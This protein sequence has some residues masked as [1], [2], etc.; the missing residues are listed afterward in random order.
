MKKII[1]KPFFI[2]LF[3][4]EYWPF[5]VVYGPLF[6][7]WFFLCLRARSFF[8]FNTSNPTIKNGGFLMESKK[9]IYDLIPSEYYPATLF[10]KASTLP[11]DVLKQV[12]QINLKFP[13]VGKPDIGMKG[14]MV[15][16]LENENELFLYAKDSKVD[17]LVQEFVPYS[18]EAGI[19]YYRYPNEEIG[20]ISGVVKKE[21]LA[22]AGDGVSTLEQLLLQNKRAVLQLPVLRKTERDKMGIVLRN[23]EELIVVPY[24]NH[25]R[26][27]KF[28]DDS[29]L[30]DE[31]LTVTIDSICKKVNGFYFGRLDIRYNDWE[32]LKQGKNFSII[33]LN[34][35]GSEPT[36]IY[37]SKHS[38]FWAWK[39]IIKH[40][41]ILY[42]ISKMN[43]QLQKTP[44]MTIPMGLDMFKQNSEYIKLLSSN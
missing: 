13:I 35:S 4:W 6:P 3:N 25:V 31:E 11:E 18:N 26:G 43:H 12:K 30:I 28:L 10:F 16:K 32:E 21:F 22:V 24:G 40:W 5:N 34:G 20:H 42:R 8:F 14:L 15:K 17:F 44:Y 9:E 33:E 37:D 2:K 38:V 7:Y 29:R 36:H 23:D 1:Y 39:E 41:R 27:A 19:F